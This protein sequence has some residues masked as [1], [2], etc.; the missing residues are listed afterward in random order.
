MLTSIDKDTYARFLRCGAASL[1][2]NRVAVNDLN[3]F[4]VPD[5]D[6]GDNMFMTINAGVEASSGETLSELSEHASHGMLLGARGNSGVILSRIFAGISKGFA[7]LDRADLRDFSHAMNLGIKESYGAVSHPVE[8]TILS[9][10]KDAVSAADRIC[11]GKDDIGEYIEAFTCEAEK[12][13]ERTPE[14][15]DVLKKAGVVDSG[16]AGLLYIFKGIENALNGD[17]SGDDEAFSS[18]EKKSVDISAF[19]ENSTLEYGYCTEFL[20]RLQSSKVDTERFD[21]DVI[22]NYLMS[23]G[24][25]VVAFRDGTVYKAHV[26]TMRPGDILNYCQRYGEF[27]TLKIENM[28]LQHSETQSKSAYVPP[29]AKKKYGIVAVASGDGLCKLFSDIGADEVI[30]GGQSMNPSSEDFLN[31]FG[32]VNAETVFVLPNNKNIFMAAKQAA[33]LY[34]DSDIKIVPSR[35]VGEGYV[36]LSSLDTSLENP[37]EILAG[38]TEAMEAVRTCMVSRASRDVASV[39]A[40]AGDFIG[41]EEDEI[42]SAS[43]KRADALY[44]LLDK[45]RAGERDVIVLACGSDVTEDEAAEVYAAL[46]EKYKMTEIIMLDGGQPVYDYIAILQ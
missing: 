2:K 29:R 17:F 19:D 3:V 15:L 12:S 10:F 21:C 14:L 39:G 13:L 38:A 1:R 33:E 22:T 6:T 31:A 7:G 35:D 37:E 20:L 40:S 34:P 32:K 4:P 44:S 27:L 11:D 26:H 23:V 46:S 8:G 9:V 25:S 45:L 42:F 36:A 30:R 28:T 16:G 24:D 43:G 18:S 41:F 5:G